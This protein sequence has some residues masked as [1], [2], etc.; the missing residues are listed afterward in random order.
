MTTTWQSCGCTLTSRVWLVLQQAC[1]FHA[2][3]FWQHQLHSAG[4]I[5]LMHVQPATMAQLVRHL[6]EGLWEE[7]WQH[8]G[9]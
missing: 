4:V 9:L 2:H 6:P 1:L 7:S 5:A 3:A 8:A